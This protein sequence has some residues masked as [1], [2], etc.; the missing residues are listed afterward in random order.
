MQIYNIHGKKHILVVD[1]Q[2]RMVNGTP[3]SIYGNMDTLNITR[4]SYADLGVPVPLGRKKNAKY[5]TLDDAYRFIHRFTHRFTN[6]K[7]YNTFVY[8]SS[9]ECFVSVAAIS[10]N[11]MATKSQ[12]RSWIKK[13]G[14]AKYD[15][16]GN[17]VTEFN[18]GNKRLRRSIRINDAQFLISE[19][20][21]HFFDHGFVETIENA[22]PTSSPPKKRL[23]EEEDS[24]EVIHIEVSESE[25][26][27][28]KV[29]AEEE[30]MTNMSV[31]SQM[32]KVNPGCPQN[33]RNWG[34][35]KPD[36]S[37]LI[38]PGTCG[39][40][41]NDRKSYFFDYTFGGYNCTTTLCECQLTKIGIVPS[42]WVM[43][44]INASYLFKQAKI[45]RVITQARP[46]GP[47]EFEISFFGKCV[48]VPN[49]AVHQP[50]GYDI[51]QT[52]NSGDRVE[53]LVAFEK[54]QAWAD[55]YVVKRC[56]DKLLYMVM[57]TE[58]FGDGYKGL[59]K[60]AC[61]RMRKIK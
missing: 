56:K 33:C 20:R 11:C 7:P 30:K 4:L 61:Y 34:V 57:F 51:D 31:V 8:N 1:L 13:H 37:Y 5:I 19:Y 35:E 17:P 60:A 15:Y 55:A 48:R 14:I 16:K 10:D 38:E 41:F 58:Y 50:R 9:N 52:Y 25:E 21:D 46:I 36:G 23:R 28:P 3:Y 53:V 45:N 32:T 47:N 54:F 43:R 6:G 22:C 44:E 40:P 12:I 42:L 24:I 39:K 26:E 18:V 59:Q 29:P 2:K 49:K 27:E